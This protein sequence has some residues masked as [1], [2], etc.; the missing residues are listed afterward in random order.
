MGVLFHGTEGLPFLWDGSDAYDVR[1]AAATTGQNAY[2]ELAALAA[3][4]NASG[5][6]V[7]LDA[8]DSPLHTSTPFRIFDRT[9]QA[10]TGLWALINAIFAIRQLYAYVASYRAMSARARQHRRDSMV[11]P[12]CALCLMV[13]A[14]VTFITFLV[15]GPLLE[16]THMSSIPWLPF[17]VIQ[18]MTYSTQMLATLL[19]SLVFRHI[20]G[21]VDRMMTTIEA[22][23]STLALAKLQAD[24]EAAAAA[25]AATPTTEEGLKS[26]A[27]DATRKTSLTASAVSTELSRA[28]GLRRSDLSASNASAG[29]RRSG[30]SASN[31]S[32]AGSNV[33][34]AAAAA[35][36]A[37]R[38]SVRSTIATNERFKNVFV[39]AVVL[40]VIVD[41]AQ[42][43]A[44]GLYVMP[45]F[46]TMIMMA[47][48]VLTMLSIGIWFLLQGQRLSAMLKRSAE[49]SPAA[50]ERADR[51]S[52]LVRRVGA[53][54]VTFVSVLIAAEAA[55]I[56]VCCDGWL[57][58]TVLCPL[59]TL[60]LVA[61]LLW[62]FFQI[63]AFK[64][65]DAQATVSPCACLLKM[66]PPTRTAPP[67]AS[68]GDPKIVADLSKKVATAYVVSQ[69]S[70]RLSDS[71]GKKNKKKANLAASFAESMGELSDGE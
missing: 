27:A 53:C 8:V 54:M 1:L 18:T 52:R 9:V 56:G 3:E 45:G 36:A 2:A 61:R 30:L 50:R 19:L 39:A 17:R 37:L 58:W 35:A 23:P 42:S 69:K 44:T 48:V 34:A 70:A 32:N 16:H 57:Y 13:L 6:I 71:M 41:T 43:V 33:S 10:L 24:E 40:L 25:A 51:M 55:R 67:E 22:R 68:D 64:P 15:D 62:S 47:Y 66:K 46:L 12:M 14:E 5:V 59:W 11:K 31:F 65:S 60:G 63:D 28:S 7:W 26:G 4:R 38:T 21:Q 20:T 49:I 29:C